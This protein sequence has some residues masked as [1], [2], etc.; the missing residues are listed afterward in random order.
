M[1]EGEWEERRSWR[2][3]SG[4]AGEEIRVRMENVDGESEARG[5]LRPEKCE[6]RGRQS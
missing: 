1:E 2:R 4:G 3:V 6:K 5:G